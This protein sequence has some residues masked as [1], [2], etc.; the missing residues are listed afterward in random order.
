[1]MNINQTFVIMQRTTFY[2]IIEVN[3]KIKF[4]LTLNERY[5]ISFGKIVFCK[6][7]NSNPVAYKLK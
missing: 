3:I 1:M 7:I 6:V 5:S 4:R 2:K